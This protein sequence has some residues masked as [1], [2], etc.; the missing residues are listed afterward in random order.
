[1]IVAVFTEP[2]A[3]ACEILEQVNGRAHREACVLGDG[4]LAQLIARALRTSACAL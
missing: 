3:A 4:K 1:M 2:L